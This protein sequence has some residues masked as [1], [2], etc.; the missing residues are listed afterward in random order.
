MN[1][2]QKIL[3]DIEKNKP[4]IVSLPDLKNLFIKLEINF[5]V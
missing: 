5:Y 4:A 2:R 3:A 1:S